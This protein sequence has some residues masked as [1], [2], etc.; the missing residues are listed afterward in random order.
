[1]PSYQYKAVDRGGRPARGALDAVNEI[2]LELRLRRMGLDLITYRQLDQK[3]SR[4]ANSGRITRQD[5]INFCFDM[6]QMS[7]SG[8]PLIDGLRDLRDTIDS[9]RLREVL[10]AMTEDMEGGKVM[11]QCMA[12][13][14]GVFDN[15]FVS[16]VRA[17]EQTGRMAEV[18]ENL[19]ASLKWQ[20]ELVSQTQRLLIYPAMVLIVVIAVVAFLLVFLVPQVVS[21]LKTMGIALPVQTRVLIFASNLVI[22]YWPLVLGAPAAAAAALVFV[23]RRNPVAAYMWDYTKLHVPLTGPILQKIIL[24]RFANFFALMYQSG[25]TVLEALRT[26]ESIVDNRV[27][28][29]GVMRAGQQITAGDNLTEAFRNLG[30][31]PPLVIRMLHVGENTGALDTALNNVSYFYTRDVRESVDKALKL[32]EPTLT[33]GLGV[34][35]ALILWSVLS[36]VYDILGKLKF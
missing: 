16:L 12:A 9:P 20:D 32:L 28:A 21:L 30:M 33:L 17:G 36:P 7:R 23:V 22:D 15:V 34:L 27:I 1:M 13:H 35:L 10:T 5:L 25:I 31:F 18:F 8:I 11:S 4:F 3:V 29:D 14:P 19:A 2:D 26:C 6:E 24:A